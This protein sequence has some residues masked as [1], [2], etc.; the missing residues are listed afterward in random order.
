M[1]LFMI[2]RIFSV[3]L[4]LLYMV[5]IFKI[6]KPDGTKLYHLRKNCPRIVFWKVCTRCEYESL[7]NSRQIWHCVNKKSFKIDR[8]RNI[9]SCRPW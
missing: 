6:L 3:S 5:T 4:S 1:K 8:G 9:R 7:C 2:F